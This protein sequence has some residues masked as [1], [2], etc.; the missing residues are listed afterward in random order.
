MGIIESRSAAN[1]YDFNFQRIDND[2]FQSCPNLS[3][4]IAVMEKTNL[5]TV[6]LLEAGWS[7]VGSWK[8]IWK[9]SEK[10]ENGNSINGKTIIKN[11]AK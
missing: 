9:N 6:F 3:I 1:N 2:Y 7:D 4:D 8:T 11:T 10:D 5:G